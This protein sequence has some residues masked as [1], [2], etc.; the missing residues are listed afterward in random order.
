VGIAGEFIYFK[1]HHHLDEPHTE[2]EHEQDFIH[3]EWNILYK[4]VKAMK[5]KTTQQANNMM[6]N[7]NYSE[8][9]REYILKKLKL[10]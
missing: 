7:L 8:A 5:P 10:K 1:K 6:K 4:K 3:K 2:K 9:E